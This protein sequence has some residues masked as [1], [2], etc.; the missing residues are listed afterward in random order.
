MVGG[1]VGRNPGVRTNNLQGFVKETSMTHALYDGAQLHGQSI[2]GGAIDVPGGGLDKF[3][4]TNL[5]FIMGCIPTRRCVVQS[6]RS[7][8]HNNPQPPVTITPSLNTE[9]PPPGIGNPT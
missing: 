5:I 4:H 9:L 2:H 1:K 8:V 6:H 7:G 3:K